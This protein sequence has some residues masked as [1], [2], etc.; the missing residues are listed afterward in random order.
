M[1]RDMAGFERH[2]LF[3]LQKEH[4]ATPFL[5]FARA[6]CLAGAVTV[7]SLLISQTGRRHSPIS[8]T[9]P[10]CTRARRFSGVSLYSLP[11]LLFSITEDVRFGLSQ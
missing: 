7:T 2:A 9:L 10:V 5:S 8:N 11:S 1:A 3:F 6:R 4:V